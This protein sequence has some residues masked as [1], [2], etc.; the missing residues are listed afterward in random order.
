MVDFVPWPG[1][2]L[3]SKLEYFRVSNGRSQGDKPCM[4]NSEHPKRENYRGEQ[5]T[6]KYLRDVIFE[7]TQRVNSK[8][9]VV[10][11]LKENTIITESNLKLLQEAM[12]KAEAETLF[13]PKNPNKD[14][15][16]FPDN[17]IIIH[18]W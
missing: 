5:V 1:S 16:P 15:S 10:H 3:K 7:H 14:V 17:L 8:I 4:P 12:Q 18:R 9:Y 6:G 2:D 13:N 11:R